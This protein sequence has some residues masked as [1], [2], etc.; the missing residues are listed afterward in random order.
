MHNRKKLFCYNTHVCY[1]KITW[2]KK[3]SKKCWPVTFVTVSVVITRK[4][5]GAYYISALSCHTASCRHIQCWKQD[6][7]YK[8]KTKTEAVWDRSCH[9]TAVSDPKTDSYRCSQRGLDPQKGVKKFNNLLF[10]PY[11]AETRPQTH[12]GELLTAKTLPNFPIAAIF[13]TS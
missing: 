11:G 8:T 3:T 7:K 1:Q 4:N 6:Q 13:T 5:T 2:H 12:F 9:K 10:K